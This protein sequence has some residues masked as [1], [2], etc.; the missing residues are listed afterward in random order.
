M[1]VSGTGDGDVSFNRRVES[2]DA[3]SADS[4]SISTSQYFIRLNTG[5]S[6][7]AYIK[8]K[9]YSLDKACRKVT[10]ELKEVDAVGGVIAINERG[11]G[12]FPLLLQSSQDTDE[13]YFSLSSLVISER[14]WNVQ[15]SD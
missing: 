12:R 3:S 13:V 6:L 14:Q 4:G 7:A 2:F 8:L 15:R 11:Q 5:S 9:G 10:G 1:G